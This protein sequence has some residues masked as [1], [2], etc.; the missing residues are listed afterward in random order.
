[1]ARRP[2]RSTRFTTIWFAIAILTVALVATV[3]ITAPSP[4]PQTP[5]DQFTDP[6]TD[7]IG[8]ENGVW[9]NEPIEVNQTDGLSDE[10][11]DLFVAQ[12]MAR[13]EVLRD[14]E[15][16]RDIEVD[17]RPRQQTPRGNVVV[18][19]STEPTAPSFDEL[20]LQAMLLT[21]ETTDGDRISQQAQQEGVLGYYLI[22]QD[23]LVI[24]TDDPE[25]LTIR[26]STLIHEL[27]HGLQDQRHDL[28]ADRFQPP[29][30][31]AK[32]AA[33]LLVE[34]ESMY[35]EQ[36]YLE[37][38]RTNEWT[39][40]P[41]PQTSSE[42]TAPQTSPPTGVSLRVLSFFPYSEGPNYVESLYSNGGWDAVDAAFDDPPTTARA[43]YDGTS[44]PTTFPALTDP[45]GNW[46]RFDARGV[47]GTE[48]VGQPGLYMLFW[49]QSYRHDIGVISP[50]TLF[51]TDG[52]GPYTYTAGPAAHF[53]ADELT[54]YTKGD[55]GGY[56]WQTEWDDPQSA[57]EFRLAYESILRGHG[58]VSPAPG[59]WTIAT[60]GYADHF[61]VYQSGTTVV[62]V[63]AETAAG[64]D[65]LAAALL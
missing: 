61:R 41:V 20:T 38:C 57:T 26:G 33:D 52:R 17:V 45:D 10:E 34:G 54:P 43:A 31:D 32:F 37:R 18:V 58:G 4:E 53:V 40:I 12:S 60:G 5:D 59:V 48:S 3:V 36:L 55:S 25:G 21:E 16:I 14:A 27:N 29:T 50:Q 23:R 28:A 44:D 1:M 13:V 19:G 15:F 11:L 6:R 47:N 56:I 65:E 39:C 22:G 51:A 42:E 49:H 8:W 63:N 24:I 30:Q 35:I 64:A 2:S 46:T 9:Y 62:I 7:T